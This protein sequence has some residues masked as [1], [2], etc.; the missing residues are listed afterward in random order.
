MADPQARIVGAEVI[1]DE[2]AEDG[3]LT[4]QVPIGIP[5]PAQPSKKEVDRHNLTHIN[6]RSWCPHCVAGR[7]SNSQHR[8]QT[9]NR[10]NVPLFCADYCYVKDVDDPHPLTVMVGRLYPSRA[11]FATACDTK[12]AEDEAVGRLATFFNESGLP[13][14]VYKTDQEHSLKSAIG[15]ALRR[16]GKSG[17]FE[18]FE[19]VPENSAVGKSASNGRAERAVQA[20][21]DLLRT[22]KSA[23]EAR[24]QSKIPVSHPVMRWLIEHTANV[25]TRYSVNPDGQ[26]PYQV[27]HG[28]RFIRTHC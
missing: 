17:T 4:V 11:M 6:Y 3:E 21:E 5:E 18:A 19:A 23:L 26:T 7:R 1:D 2:I 15:E 14:L 16:T 10:R 13:K 24:L 25:L 27:L 8:S 28:K 22:L 12:G 9:S 20:V